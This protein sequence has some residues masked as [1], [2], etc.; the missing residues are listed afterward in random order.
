M[1]YRNLPDYIF[2]SRYQYRDECGVFPDNGID[3]P[4]FKL[5]LQQFIS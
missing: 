2:P 1:R 5:R 3:F 4:F